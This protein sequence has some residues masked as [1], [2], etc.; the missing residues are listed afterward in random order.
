MYRFWS[1]I[2]AIGALLIGCFA[3]GWPFAVGFFV[4]VFVLVP[5]QL[6]LIKCFCAKRGE[7]PFL[8]KMTLLVSSN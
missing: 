5:A 2:T 7:F 8:V 6:Y 3:V 4:L 1:P